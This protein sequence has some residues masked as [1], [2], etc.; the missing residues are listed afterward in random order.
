V[1]SA[2]S[3]CRIS[4]NQTVTLA[5][6]WDCGNHQNGPYSSRQKYLARIYNLVEQTQNTIEAS[7]QAAQCR[8][9]TT[10]RVRSRCRAAR[11]AGNS[12]LGIFYNSVV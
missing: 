5:G 8:M 4:Q 9:S 1:A 12:D 10:R 6:H 3:D 7:R 11:K 2:Q